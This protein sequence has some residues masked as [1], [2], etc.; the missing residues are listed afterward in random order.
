MAH[1][2]HSLEV[3]HKKSGKLLFGTHGLL[4]EDAGQ[5][6]SY[7]SSRLPLYRVV[8]IDRFTHKIIEEYPK[9]E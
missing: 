1:T 5:V 4:P 2:L 8:V 3:R 7:L 6:A 9:N